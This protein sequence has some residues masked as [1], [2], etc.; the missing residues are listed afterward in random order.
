MVN[1][2]AKISAS[3]GSNLSMPSSTN[4]LPNNISSEINSV[5]NSIK[6]SNIAFLLGCDDFSS[7]ATLVKSKLPYYIG[8]ELSG[9]SG[10]FPNAYTIEI[11]SKEPID[12]VTVAF[13]TLRN[14]YPTNIIID[15]SSSV[16]VN[17]STVALSFESGT[18][19]T[20]YI[21]NWS[22]VGYPLI[23]QGISSGVEVEISVSKLLKIDFTGRARG[24]VATASWGIYSNSGTL[25]FI[26]SA[27]L[28][29]T[30]KAQEGLYKSK[31]EVFIRSK[32]V[33]R[34]IGTFWITGGDID[35]ETNVADLTFDDGLKK[36]QDTN[37][38][39]KRL[40][41]YDNV[42]GMSLYSIME[43]VNL[44]LAAATGDG[45]QVYFADNETSLRWYKIWVKYPMIEA[46]SYWAF[47]TKCCEL[48]GCYVYADEEGKAVIK[49]G[50]GT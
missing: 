24:D 29:K 48:S 18:S 23:I 7:G 49:Y 8:A 41:T 33:D 43:Y 4:P 42:E 27:N 46:S 14:H 44:N 21:S 5:L 11:E 2:C 1:V 37:V 50:G 19:H 6:A 12:M 17:S 35:E 32:N 3:S 47:L 13:D 28:I 31:L 15:Y 45:I 30:L 9:S 34:L 10:F 16:A 39:G 25:S 26:D 38:K 22:A 20:L 40:I 36:W